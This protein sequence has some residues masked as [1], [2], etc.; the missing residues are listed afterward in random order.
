MLFIGGAEG[1][2]QLLSC[3]MVDGSRER[4]LTLG[5][6]A[7]RP[8][9][10]HL[11]C[12]DAK[13]VMSSAH[14]DVLQFTPFASRVVTFSIN[15]ACSTSC[16]LSSSRKL[17]VSKLP[18]C[19]RSEVDWIGHVCATSYGVVVPFFLALLFAKQHLTMRQCKTFMAYSDDKEEVTLQLQVMSAT[20]SLKEGH[21]AT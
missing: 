12:R 17:A 14:A 15:S 2:A 10:P 5:D 20:E 8:L 18:R 19:P 13:W 21:V 7:F 11:R 4:P 1:T 6:F 9:M 3:Q 16:R